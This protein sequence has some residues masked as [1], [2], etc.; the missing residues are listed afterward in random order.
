LAKSSTTDVFYCRSALRLR[1]SLRQC[2]CDLWTSL[3]TPYPSFRFAELGN[4]VGYYLPR[5]SA[6]GLR[7]GKVS[8]LP[9]AFLENQR[10]REFFGVPQFHS[11]A[12]IRLYLFLI[13]GIS[14][15]QR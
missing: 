2:G 7:V 5:L 13:S 8:W 4:G 10:Q 1:S 3:P 15:H 6:L 9:V 14:V 12:L 11:S